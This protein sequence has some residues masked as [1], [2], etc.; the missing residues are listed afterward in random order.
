MKIFHPTILLATMALLPSSVVSKKDR[1]TP[2]RLFRVSR[3]KASKAKAADASTPT[4]GADDP[5]I[6]VDSKSSKCSKTGKAKSCKDAFD[7]GFS[8]STSMSYSMR[9]LSE[10]MFKCTD[11]E[12]DLSHN[13]PYS[14][15]TDGDWT[16]NGLFVW[17]REISYCAGVKIDFDSCLV[18]NVLSFVPPHGRMLRAVD[19]PLSRDMQSMNEHCYVATNDEVKDVVDAAKYMCAVSNQEV[20]DEE[21]DAAFDSFVAMFTNNECL[22]SRA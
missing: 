3:S 17:I 7:L 21:Y 4:I 10:E 19:S 20:G 9:I 5:S 22:C 18:E 8:M 11:C 6:P 2:H 16:E 12:D 1:N 14:Y 15:D 13:H